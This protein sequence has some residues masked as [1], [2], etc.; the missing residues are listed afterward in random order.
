MAEL[1]DRRPP[2]Q[3]QYEQAAELFRTLSAPLRLAII[4]R[5]T[6]GPAAVHELV[7]ATGESQPLVS[8]HL[9]VLRAARLIRGQVQGRERVYS[10][11][12]EHVA[13]IVT[14]AIR[15]TSEPA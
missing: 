4:R 1:A 14:D 7:A 10:L 8:Q 12:D 2:R 15:H 5:L 3:E 6:G 11:T 13:H 9:R